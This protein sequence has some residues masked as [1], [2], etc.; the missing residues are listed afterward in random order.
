MLPWRVSMKRPAWPTNVMSSFDPPVC[1][2]VVLCRCRVGRYGN[3]QI[4]PRCELHYTVEES[5]PV[6]LGEAGEGGSWIAAIGLRSG[7]L[8]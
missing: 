1:Y 6:G 4:P 8:S 5:P 3:D 7:W 2:R